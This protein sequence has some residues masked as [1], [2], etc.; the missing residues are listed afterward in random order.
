MPTAIVYIM[1][2]LIYVYI[3]IDYSVILYE[4]LILKIYFTILHR[5]CAPA[6]MFYRIPYIRII[7]FIAFIFERHEVHLSLVMS[8]FHFHPRNQSYFPLKP[9]L[10][11]ALLLTCLCANVSQRQRIFIVIERFHQ[12][13]RDIGA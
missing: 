8:N 12:L 11:F 6:T 10:I 4:I 3:Y 13:V 1:Y 2:I 7:I 9:A 5:G